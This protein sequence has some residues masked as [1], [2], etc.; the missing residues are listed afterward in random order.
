MTKT[1]KFNRSVNQKGYGGLD[2]VEVLK[3][4]G[5]Y[6]EAGGLA[7]K[8][9][10]ANSYGAHYGMKSSRDEAVRDFKRGWEEA[11]YDRPSVSRKEG[12]V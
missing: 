8:S 6:F 2:Q 12:G 1:V 4:Q 5:K 11:R 10:Y 3:R 9:G 7:Y